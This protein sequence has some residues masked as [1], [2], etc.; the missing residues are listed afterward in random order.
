MA[1]ELL[2]QQQHSAPVP[3]TDNAANNADNN[4]DNSSTKPP[5]PYDARAADAWALGVLTFLLLAGAYPFEDERHPS[6]VAHTVSNVLAARRRPLPDSASPG[7]ARVVAGLLERDPRRRTALRALASDPWLVGGAER[8][9]RGVPGGMA[10]VDLSAVAGG[11]GGGAGA[12]KDKPD[13]QGQPQQQPQPPRPAAA[14]AAAVA[15]APPAAAPAASGE[16][17]RQQPGAPPPPPPPP[18]S[19]LVQRLMGSMGLRKK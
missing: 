14:E 16:G 4:N 17:E 7:A 9:A 19:G 10:L 3:F 6:S 18:K 2:Q 5:P 13:G 11:A 8:H 15:A 12:D 1:P